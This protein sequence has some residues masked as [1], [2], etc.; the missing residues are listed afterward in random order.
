MHVHFTNNRYGSA[1]DHPV[2]DENEAVQIAV[3]KKF[4][5]FYT[6]NVPTITT[7]GKEFT[8]PAENKSGWRYVNIDKIYT[9]DD[10]INSFKKE[11]SALPRPK[12]DFEAVSGNVLKELIDDFS[13]KSPDT[14]FIL[15]LDQ[16]PDWIELKAEEKVFDST[17]KKLWPNL[18]RCGTKPQPKI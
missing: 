13:Q 16:R 17:G 7:D 6:Y 3:D 2:K 9:L 12:N 5:R 18:V 14:R 10:V 4:H 15:S 8:A 1:G 11:L